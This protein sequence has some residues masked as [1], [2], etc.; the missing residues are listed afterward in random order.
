M[1]IT[2]LE[3][4]SREF[5]A[6]LFGIVLRSTIFFLA[7]SVAIFFLRSRTVEIRHL[8]WRGVL[9]GLLLLPVIE[10]TTPPIRHP[11]PIL[12]KA[13]MTLFPSPPVSGKDEPVRAALPSINPRRDTRTFPWMLIA[14]AI[15]TFFTSILLIRLAVSLLHLKYIVR[16]SAPIVDRDLRELAYD[17]WLESHL[18]LHPPIRVSAN[19]CVPLATGFREVSILLPSAWKLWPRD[20]LQAVLVHEMAHARRK[21]PT[22]A[23]LGSLALCVFWL[24]PLVY[25]LRR[26]LRV[27]SEEACDDAAL[28]VT[29]PERYAQ[30]LIEFAADVATVGNRVSA[31]SS[32]AV[33]R[34]F[35]K[36]RLE[37]I[38]SMHRS[39]EKDSRLL[40]ALL[41]SLFFPALYL[42]A[43]TR[44]EQTP[45]ARV[46]IGNQKQAD[47]LE[48]SLR[49]DPNNI[50]ERSTLITFYANERNHSGLTQHLLWMIDHDPENPIVAIN[51]PF[52]SPD[53]PPHSLKESIAEHTT[54]SEN[55][56]RLK[57]AW[58]RAF[59]IHS[60][61][62]E[63]LYHAGLFLEQEDPQRA[64]ALFARAHALT[65]DSPDAQERYLD[66]IALLYSAAVIADFEG[67]T[68][69][70][71]HS[72]RMS[73]H[74]SGTLRRELDASADPAFLSKVG[75]RLIQF[76]NP[77]EARIG[78]ALLQKA[79]DIDPGNYKWKEALESAQA[80]PIRRRNRQA[81]SNHEQAGR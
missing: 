7:A 18:P 28:Q 73:P 55:Y 70:G 19:V 62:A 41:V 30:I 34:S 54:A 53:R 75:T 79:I 16:Q 69:F 61:S 47:D 13:E 10:F 25:W 21:D 51:V 15:Y 64:L 1:S 74:L 67:T 50:I 80:E 3:A 43:A 22:T 24:H 78:L 9:Y 63:V 76:G 27:L 37:R 52:A 48:S 14:S 77:Q 39:V 65:P 66:T 57:A 12:I 2:G 42:T 60:D 8:I 20:K 46:A 33:D 26:Q 44:F 36:K 72:I 29:I 11:T 31:T 71:L 40:R 32:A 6:I 23:L 56:E 68:S 49:R 4:V 81:L 35:I 17:I 58:E 5:G 59:A 38:F 45:A